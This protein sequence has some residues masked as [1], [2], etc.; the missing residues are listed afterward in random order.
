MSKVVI[1]I[2]TFRRPEMLKQTLDALALMVCSH[3]VA[4]LVGDN[5]TEGQQ[6][7]ALVA[8]LSESYRFPIK[9]MVIERRGHPAA[10]NGLLIAALARDPDFI[11]FLD[12]DQ[13]VDPNYLEALVDTAERDSSDLVGPAVWPQFEEPA[14]QW[15]RECKIYRRDTDSNGPVP[16]LTGDGGI[17]VRPACLALLKGR[18]YDESFGLSGGAD[19]ELFQRLKEVGA[20]FSRCSEAK[21]LEVYPLS[22]LTVRWAIS[23]AY[24]LGNT[25]FRLRR[26]AGSPLDII[27]Y[28]KIPAGIAKA[29][30]DLVFNLARPHKQVDALCMAARAMGKLAFMLG[31]VHEDYR[32]THGR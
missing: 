9:C 10:R 25:A 20:T 15:V 7:V 14:P 18:Y 3:S 22:R 4:L 12:D 31:S 29:A 23:R 2:P 13:I 16:I 24:R 27:D 5:D 17:L 1:C 8:S 30:L 28:A 21:V 26:I 11:V 19:T 32:R 6:G